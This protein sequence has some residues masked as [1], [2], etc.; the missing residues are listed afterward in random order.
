MRPAPFLT[1]TLADAHTRAITA[2]RSAAAGIGLDAFVDRVVADLELGPPLSKDSERKAASAFDV[3]NKITDATGKHPRGFWLPMEATA[4]RA[5]NITTTAAGKETV[6]AAHDGALI[7]ALR[8]YSG[9]LNA[10]ATLIT[11]LSQGNLIMPRATDG[12]G[13]AWVG[14]FDAAAQADPSFDQLIVSPRTVSATV[15]ISRRLLKM[16]SFRDR[17]ESIIASELMAALWSEVDRV[18]LAGS[19]VGNEPAGLLADPD[20]LTIGAGDNGAAPSLALL[21]D[22]EEALG[23]ASGRTPSAWFTTPQAR[24]TLRQT[25]RSPGQSH[26]LWSDDNRMLGYAANATTH[27]PANGEKGDGEGLSTLALGDWSQLLISIW[28]GAAVDVVVNP[29]FTNGR[30]TV[31]AFLD[32]GI[33]LRHPQA[34]AIC[35]DVVTPA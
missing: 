15:T 1:R 25:A 19:G 32:I 14:E 26:P 33:G 34:F 24:R 8:P 2:T 11:G 16:A 29:Y 27:L 21:C 6:W 10:G 18:A 23:I 35:R 7:E 9:M 12:A 4:S 5:L 28:G 13:V 31:S 20:T 30:A 22:M 3:S 17:V